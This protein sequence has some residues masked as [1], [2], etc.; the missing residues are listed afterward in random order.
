MLAYHLVL[1]GLQSEIWAR[2][3]CIAHIYDYHQASAQQPLLVF[4]NAYINNPQAHK[5][6]V[7]AL[8]P[9]VFRVTYFPQETEVFL[10]ANSS[11]DNTRKADEGREGFLWLRV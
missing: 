4:L 3:T 2:G 8:H 10:L 9:E 5:I 11:K 6:T 1:W 7:V